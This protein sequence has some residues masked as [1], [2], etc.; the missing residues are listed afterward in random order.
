MSV[1]ELESHIAKL[2]ADIDTQKEVLR[3]LEIQKS[4][5]QR[6]L[7]AIHDPVAR[8]PLEIS[9]EIFIRCIPSERPGPEPRVAPVLLLNICNAWTDIALSTPALWAA[10]HLDCH[11]QADEVLKTWLQRAN[12]RPL[13]IS[14]RKSLNDGVA[15]ILRQYAKQLKHLE[16]C[17]EEH[18]VDSLTK[19]STFSCVESLTF[20]SPWDDPA[21]EFNSLS[22]GH[23][24]GLL[25]RAPNL[26]ECYFLNVSIRIPAMAP[27]RMLLPNL[28]RLKFGNADPDHP[29]GGDDLL[30]YLS[31]PTLEELAVPLIDIF[32]HKFSLFLERSLPPLRRLVLGC[33]DIQMPSTLNEWL[34]ILP[35]LIDLELCTRGG[36]FADDFFSALVDSPSEFLPNLRS[37]KMQHHYLTHSVLAH[38]PRVLSARRP[39]LVC[40]HL[41]ASS[42]ERPSPDVH[43]ALLNLAT[44]GMEIYIGNDRTNYVSL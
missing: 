15:A 10:V 11:D 16:F 36:P 14:L 44:D 5:A 13:S 12:R 26:V 23:V 1:E 41:N 9:S 42:A 4:A 40:F 31:L 37:L 3:Q 18:D 33:R 30:D 25:C 27:E 8:L 17:E 32:P 34:F 38:V 6:Q 7:N 2:S 28:R 20:G 39:R 19:E 22:L 21:E 43:D 35:S 24:M 29:H